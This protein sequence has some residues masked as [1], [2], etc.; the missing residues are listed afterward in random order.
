MTTRNIKNINISSINVLNDINN[1]L[2]NV[3]INNSVKIPSSSNN[4]YNSNDNIN[5]GILIK[6]INSNGSGIFYRLNVNSDEYYPTPYLYFNNNVIID[7]SNLLSELENTLQYYP[8]ELSNLI[9]TGGYIN[10]TNG[11]NSNIGGD[12]VGLRYS[13]NNTVQFKN[14]DTDWIELSSITTHDKF[15]ELSDVDVYS[16]PLLD[17][18]I[19]TYDAT[20]NLFVNSNLSIINDNNPY[21]GG[22]LYTGN[23]T[24]FS[25]L[26]NFTLSYYNNNIT[27]PFVT[28]ANN[29]TSTGSGAYF[30]LAN[31]DISGITDPELS[32]YG[33]LSD[34]GMTLTTKGNGNINLNASYGNIVANCDSIIVSGFIQNS[35]YRCNTYPGGFNSNVT[36]NIP[37]T[38]DTIL[39]NFNNSNIGGTYYA[40]IGSGVDGQK[41]NIIYNNKSINSITVLANF[42]GGGSGGIYTGTGL[43]TGL[44]FNTTGQSSTLIYLG[45]DIDCWQILNSGADTY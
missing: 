5:A 22:N 18:Q 20:S 13:S 19:I 35:I 21:L 7:E 28:F 29:T 31:A 3:T 1:S 42:N 41:L 43:S 10:F 24:I 34:I 6:D 26:N 33:T 2:G 12:G 39:F 32:V 9:V 38:N 16:N 45:Q 17:N 23:H 15:T 37:L 44:I 30:K 25:Q 36:Q 27:N 4:T 11:L 14:N 8:L 40:N